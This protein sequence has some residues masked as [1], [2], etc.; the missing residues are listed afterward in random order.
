M[1]GV[2]ALDIDTASAKVATGMPDD[3]DADYAIPVWAG[4]L[5][6]QSMLTELESDDRVIDGIEPSLVVRAMQGK[7]I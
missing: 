7:V 4:V 1:T 3:E 5:P 2:V 6:L